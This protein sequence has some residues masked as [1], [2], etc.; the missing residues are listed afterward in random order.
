[1]NFTSILSHLE[2]IAHY[3]DPSLLDYLNLIAE[4]TVPLQLKAGEKF[5]KV[6]YEDN[7]VAYVAEGVFR[8][9]STDVSGREM[10]IRLPAEGDFTMFLEDYK[11]LNPH[12]DYAWEA[13]TDS[14]ILTWGKKDLEFLALNIPSWNFLTL[15]I[16][17]TIILRLYVERGEMFNDNATVRYLK[18]SERHPT[19][20]ERVPLRHIASYLGIAPQSLSRIRQQV[21]K[22]A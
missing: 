22:K 21:A 10:T 20:I 2:P 4:H 13:V 15:K 11:L 1:M 6:G 14:T 16:T 12:I 9:Y 19:L 18:F 7:Q 5:P 3:F 17:Q 8:V